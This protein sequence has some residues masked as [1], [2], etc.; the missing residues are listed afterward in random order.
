[1]SN[2]VTKSAFLLFSLWSEPSGSRISRWTTEKA[3]NDSLEEPSS[4]AMVFL[5]GVESGGGGTPAYVQLCRDGLGYEAY[6]LAPGL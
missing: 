4:T 3:Y 5:H 2:V 1:M 6:R